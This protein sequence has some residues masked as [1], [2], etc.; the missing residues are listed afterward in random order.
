M[1]NLLLIINETQTA[2]QWVSQIAGCTERD[3]FDLVAAQLIEPV[4]VLMAQAPQVAMTSLR[5]VQRLLSAV[6][7]TTLYA[8]LNHFGKE[9][10]GLME[11]YR[12]SLEVERCGD[13]TA[14][15]ALGLQFLKRL[16]DKHGP[17]MVRK[18]AKALSAGDEGGTGD[19]LRSTG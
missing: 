2:G 3:L 17:D 15:R 1:R 14:L 6:T 5:D 8:A 9:G 18:F 19:P 4:P 10:L 7:Y 16:Q 11:A 12:F 13:V